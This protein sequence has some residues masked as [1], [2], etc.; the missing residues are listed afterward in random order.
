[1]RTTISIDPQLLSRAKQVAAETGRTLSQVVEDSLQEC[2]R[3]QPSGPTAEF[4]MPTFVGD[5]LRPGVDID[6]SAGLQDLMDQDEHL[7]EL[8]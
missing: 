7:D 4:H 6:D 1:M 5:G 3:R 2:F 8:R